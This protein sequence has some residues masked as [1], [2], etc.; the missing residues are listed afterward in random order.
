MARGQMGSHLERL[1]PIYKNRKDSMLSA[2]EDA[3]AGTGT[4]WTDPDGGFF[5]WLTLP[6][7]VNARDLFPDALAH[8]VAYVP[9]DAFATKTPFDSSLRLCFASN[10]TERAAEGIN[11][12]KRTLVGKYSEEWPRPE[13]G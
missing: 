3:F 11:R 5:T 7:F 6:E 9:G 2:L 13:R 10:T 12:L 1:T 4:E 8:G